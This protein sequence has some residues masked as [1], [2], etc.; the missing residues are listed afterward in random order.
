LTEPAAAARP[1]VLLT[2]PEI[3]SRPVQAALHTRG[4]D[5]ALAPMLHIVPEPSAEADLTGCQ[6][7]LFTSANG[8][9]AFAALSAERDLPAVCVGAASAAAARAVGFGNVEASG[10]DVTALAETV[11]ARFDPAA[12]AL[13]HA[14]GSVSAGDLQGDLS[15]AGFSVRRVP[16]YRAETAQGFDADTR[17][18][19][20]SGAFDAVAFFSPRTAA[21][22]VRVMTDEGRAP[23][24][25]TLIAACLSPAVAEAAASLSWADIA[26]AARPETPALIDAICETL[27]ARRPAR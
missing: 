22:F 12:G 27:A 25:R 20:D 18:A 19:L 26:V 2:R 10:G 5:A 7:I 13:F 1:L 11:R 14:A 23:C 9:R 3:D 6:A 16:L 15:E 17:D 21:T 24:A 8:V 4:I